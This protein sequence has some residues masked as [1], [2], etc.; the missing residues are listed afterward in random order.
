MTL[1]FIIFLLGSQNSA[2]CMEVC[3]YVA[4]SNRT[5]LKTRKYQN[6]AVKYRMFDVTLKCRLLN[7]IDSLLIKQQPSV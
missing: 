3:C 4:I 7:V 1:P 6:V 2:G 5:I